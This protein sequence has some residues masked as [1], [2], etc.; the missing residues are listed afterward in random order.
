MVNLTLR[1]LYKPDVGR[2]PW[3]YQTYG[4]DYD[5]KVLPS[6]GNEVL[7]AVVAQYNADQLLTQRDAVRT[8]ASGPEP[9]ACYEY[10]RCLGIGLVFH[11]AGV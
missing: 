10:E 8:C 6:I 5:D 2:L 4:L 1:V 3:L 11:T 7:K 9:G